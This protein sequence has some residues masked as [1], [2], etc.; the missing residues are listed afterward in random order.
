MKWL[1]LVMSSEIISVSGRNVYKAFDRHVSHV[2]NDAWFEKNLHLGLYTE[3]CSLTTIF[4]VIASHC[5]C[6]Q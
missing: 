3:Q 6:F 2:T 4:N 1:A 5:T